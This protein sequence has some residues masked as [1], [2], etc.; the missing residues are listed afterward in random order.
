[1]RQLANYCLSQNKIDLA[2]K[3]YKTCILYNPVRDLELLIVGNMASKLVNREKAESYFEECKDFNG[4]NLYAL[5]NLIEIYKNQKKT[6][7]SEYNKC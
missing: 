3:C 4:Y 1:M 6:K 7:K 2:E 5:A